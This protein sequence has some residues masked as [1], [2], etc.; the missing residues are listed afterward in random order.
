MSNHWN[1]Q[2][3]HENLACAVT[4]IRI[5]YDLIIRTLNK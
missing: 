5:P 1:V 4:N 3:V 2:T